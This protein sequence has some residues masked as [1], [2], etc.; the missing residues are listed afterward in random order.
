[1]RVTFTEDALAEYISWQSEDKKTLN[2]INQL[3][4]S[5]KLET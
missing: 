4:Q 2:R 5:I 3:I 1:M